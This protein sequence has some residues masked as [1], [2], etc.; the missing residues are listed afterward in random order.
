MREGEKDYDWWQFAGIYED[1]YRKALKTG[2]V[3]DLEKMTV[4]KGGEAELQ[5]I[6]DSPALPSMWS[7]EALMSAAALGI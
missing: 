6:R 5:Y 3:A 4:L 1:A 7:F 2:S